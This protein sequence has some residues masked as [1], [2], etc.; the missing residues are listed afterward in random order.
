MKLSDLP[1]GHKA[2]TQLGIRVLA[3]LSRRVDGYSVYV[4]A[5]PGD[6]HDEEW[7]DVMSHGDKQN[8]A[9]AKAIITSLF[10]P[11]FEIDLP[12]AY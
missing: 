8:E 11:G 7:Q 6:N 12:Y 9:V 2:Y 4:G 10:H 5:V 1:V 3:V